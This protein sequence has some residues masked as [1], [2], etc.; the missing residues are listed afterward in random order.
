MAF[1]SRTLLGLL[2]WLAVRAGSSLDFPH[3]TDSLASVATAIPE[4]VGPNNLVQP[5]RGGWLVPVPDEPEAG[6]SLVVHS[7]LWAAVGV[8]V[9]L[10]AAGYVR[11]RW[12]SGRRGG[13]FPSPVSDRDRSRK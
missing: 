5:N 12:K 9:L 8:I 6:R 11:R 1:V 13:Q 7:A 4:V 10:L 3:K 2:A